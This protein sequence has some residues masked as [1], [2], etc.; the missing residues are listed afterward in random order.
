MKNLILIIFLCTGCTAQVNSWELIKAEILCK[1]HSG[2]AYIT[3]N[4]LITS[5]YVDCFDGTTFSLNGM[6]RDEKNN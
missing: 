5:S 1:S 3:K 6:L 4:D 2:I